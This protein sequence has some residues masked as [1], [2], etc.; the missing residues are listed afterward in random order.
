MRAHDDAV[1]VRGPAGAEDLLADPGPVEGDV[2]HPE[3]ADVEAR[4]AEPRTDLEL[5]PEV[6]GRSRPLGVAPL[7]RDE[8]RVPLAGYLDGRGHGID[9]A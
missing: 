4:L 8:R 1:P 6:R 3:S 5:A 9:A 2:D 7:G